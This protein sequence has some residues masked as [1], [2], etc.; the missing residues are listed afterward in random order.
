MSETN[1][2]ILRYKPSFSGNE[3]PR[4]AVSRPAFTPSDFMQG[5]LPEEIFLGI[6]CLERK[7]AERSNKKFLLLLLDADDATKIGRHGEILSGVTKAADAARRNT[8]PAGWY[9]SNAI[10]GI[11]F[12][13]LGALD[14]AETV[15]RLL[16]RIRESLLAHLSPEDAKYVDVSAH[17]FADESNPDGA[18]A[19][20]NPALYP[21]LLHKHA[22]RRGSLLVKRAM[23]IVGSALALLFFSPLFVVIAMLVK[24]TSKGPVFFKQQR[25]GQFGKTFT[26]LKFRSMQANNDLKI[27]K[28][29]MKTVIS[30]AYDGKGDGQSKPVFKMTND[31]RITRVGRILRRSSLDELPQ[32]IN[33]LRGDMSLVGPRPPLAYEYEVY[34]L[35][36]RG[37]VLEVKPGITGLWQVKGRSRVSFDDMVRLDL[38]Y[39]RGWSL[40][41]DLQ[42]LA[43]TPGAVLLGDGAY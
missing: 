42:I 26:C 23:D 19:L 38:Q 27:H 10:L 8:D 20:A 1:S 11:I 35:W 36:H 21:D 40:W 24:L 41:L 7:R 12:T 29:F 32:F 25:L 30:G 22:A 16:D 6:L 13:E 33:V 28:E 39:A 9:K 4:R 34:D 5:I 37:R 31:P 18:N 17:I 43:K 3:H 14:D 15:N 2:A